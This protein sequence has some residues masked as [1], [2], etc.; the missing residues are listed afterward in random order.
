VFK[1]Y[2]KITLCM[3]IHIYKNSP[4]K[5][6]HSEVIHVLNYYQSWEA[7]RHNQEN[8]L[9]PLRLQMSDSISISGLQKQNQT[10]WL[11][12]G[13]SHEADL[14]GRTG[15]SCNHVPVCAS[16]GGC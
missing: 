12:D 11:S 15:S 8:F 13:I 5:S 3:Y 6:L 10:T 14:S 7:K 2:W 4:I 1:D 9:P 16:S